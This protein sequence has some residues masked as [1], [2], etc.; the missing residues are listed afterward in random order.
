M[1]G[2]VVKAKRRMTKFYLQVHS[3]CVLD[4][5]HE[6]RVRLLHVSHDGLQAA[7]SIA[8]WIPGV[9]EREAVLNQGSNNCF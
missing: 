4:N 3:G 5:Q 1:F 9:G 6:A 7:A 2:K 8:D